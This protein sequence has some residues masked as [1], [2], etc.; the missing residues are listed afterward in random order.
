MSESSKILASSAGGGGVAA[1]SH[2][3]SSSP[4]TSS[5]GPASDSHKDFASRPRV[6][7][8]LETYKMT[9]DRSL[10]GPEASEEAFNQHKYYY[11]SP[12]VY[13][14]PPDVELSKTSPPND[15]DQDCHDISKLVP[16]NAGGV[17]RVDLEASKRLHTMQMAMA[18]AAA[19]AG[20]KG[21][22]PPPPSPPPEHI[23][24]GNS[25]VT[26]SR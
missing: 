10:M 20:L 3:S 15:K 25:L 4:A 21:G 16:A 11:N 7:K 17:N 14:L 23:K 12:S 5:S 9:A 2:A 22:G 6:K 1:P 24:S 13:K 8:L 18:A 19:S 26:L